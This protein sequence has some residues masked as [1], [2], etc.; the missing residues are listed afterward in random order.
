MNNHKV[1]SNV[2]SWCTK[3]R[4]VLAHTIEAIAAGIIKRVQCNTCR[5][6]HQY[7]SAE[8]GQKPVIEKKASRTSGPKVVSSKSDYTRVMNG[9]DFQRAVDYS[10][11]RNYK[12]GELINHIKFGLGIVVG[13]KDAQKVEVLFSDGPKILLQ[14]KALA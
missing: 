12:N 11:S 5:G 13:A 14:G 1:G 7:K 8:P 10:M 4:L 3:C 2:D 6:K 9:R